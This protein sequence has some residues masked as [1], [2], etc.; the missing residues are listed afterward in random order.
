MIDVIFNLFKGGK[1]SGTLFVSIAIFVV[2]LFLAQPAQAAGTTWTV[3]KSPNG[4]ITPNSSN[5]LSGVSA[6]SDRNVWAVGSFSGNTGPNQTLAEHFNGKAWSLVK[7]PNAGTRA[8][9]S[10]VG[11]SLIGS[12]RRLLWF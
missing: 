7:T 1:T 10:S 6:I 5:T 3:V 4:S 12:L 2:S 11:T 8:V 9:A